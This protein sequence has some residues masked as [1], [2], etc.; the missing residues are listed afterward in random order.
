M[1]RRLHLF[2]ALIQVLISTGLTQDPE[3]I[4]Y[5]YG[6]A[7]T[8]LAE[9]GDYMWVGTTGGLVKIDQATG[10]TDFYDPINSDLP[11]SHVTQVVVDEAGLK[12]IGTEVGGLASFDGTSWVVYNQVNS[13]LL[14]NTILDIAIDSNGTK[15]IGSYWGGLV[16]FY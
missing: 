15:W 16:S 5:N 6:G 3:W 8:A 10:E 9:E 13:G 7:V 4:N 11:H 1:Q 14:N 12:W 2:I